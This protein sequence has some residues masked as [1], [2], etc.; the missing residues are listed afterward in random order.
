MAYKKQNFKNGQV[1]EAAHLNHMEEGIEQAMNNSGGGGGTFVQADYEQNDSTASDYIKNRPF[2]IE[3]GE[4]LFSGDVVFDSNNFNIGII[5]YDLY[6][7]YG[8]TLTDDSPDEEITAAIDAMVGKGLIVTVDGITEASHMKT[9][10]LM[11]DPALYAGNFGV[12]LQLMLDI[13]MEYGIDE[14][15]AI[16]MIKEDFPNYDT[17]DTGESFLLMVTAPITQIMAKSAGTFT[18]VLQEGNIKKIDKMFLPD[19]IGSNVEMGDVLPKVTADDEGK[20][21]MVVDGVWAISP[22]PNGDEVAY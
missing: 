7:H 16:A 5:D 20:V 21:L 2:Y 14:E 22:I 8:F 17:L 1:L 18:V 12:Y 4:Q 13:Y 3:N 15:T 6:A 11:G 19:G 9:I 10:A